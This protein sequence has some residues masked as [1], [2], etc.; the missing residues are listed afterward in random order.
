RAVFALSYRALEPAAA[1]L[2]RLLGLHPGP[3]ISTAAAASLAGQSPAQTRS[4]LGALTRVHLVEERTRG[5]YA[6]HDLL[7]A[8]A[9]ERAEEAE[10]EPERR[11]AV[12]RLLDHYLH[13]AYAAERLANPT[14]TLIKLAAP[15]PGVLPEDPGDRVR[16][17]AWLAAEHPVLV[18]A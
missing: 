2:F 12:V 13:S 7:R 1:R 11:A 16:A 3:D 4:L 18:G 17:V 8:Y 6:S 5:R 10:P 15:T 9:A 14:R